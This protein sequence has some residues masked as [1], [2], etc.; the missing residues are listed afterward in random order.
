MPSSLNSLMPLMRSRK[1]F[2]ISYKMIMWIPRF[3]FT[4]L[5]LGITFY[6]I[7]GFIKT[8]T[9]VSKAESHIL[10]NAAFYSEKGLSYADGTAKT[11]T[12]RVYPGVVETSKFK[13]ASKSKGDD[14]QLDE[15]FDH[16]K[17]L[18]VGRFVKHQTIIDHFLK[19]EAESTAYTDKR[20][21]V[22]W[23]PIAQA[24]GE[25]EGGKT[26]YAEVRYVTAPDGKG[27]VVKTVFIT[28]S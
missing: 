16:M 27:Y 25:G 14:T 28:S 18:L 26:P 19:P 3:L 5:V 11:A 4:V 22:L 2:T 10:A 12:G 1:G 21:Y 9:D 23:Q 17:P 20:R 15:F 6:V 13:E 7:L 24:G 8:A